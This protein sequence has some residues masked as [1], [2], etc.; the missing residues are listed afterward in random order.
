MIDITNNHDFDFGEG[1]INNNLDFRI[2]TSN[3]NIDEYD[4]LIFSDSK[5]TSIG[6]EKGSEW[7]TLLLNDFEK[8]GLSYLLITRPKEITVFF[9]LINFIRL[10]KI[11]SKLLIT[12]LGFVDLT[13]KKEEF[14]DDIIGQNFFNEFFLNKY[15]LC[16]YQLSSGIYAY[17]FS[18]D[19]QSVSKEIASFLEG[20]FNKTYLIESFEFSSDIKIERKRPKEFFTQLTMTNQLIN[21]IA[22]QASNI[23][24]VSVHSGMPIDQSILSYDAVHFTKEGHRFVYEKVVKSK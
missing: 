8:K 3:I 6:A 7:T 17:L 5:G 2:C 18:L 14:I 23:N 22:K 21:S 24:V 4:V 1:I 11:K 12:N 20:S 9:T 13:P 16:K 19:Y 10:N 15:Q